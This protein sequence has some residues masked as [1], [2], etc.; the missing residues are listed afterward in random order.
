MENHMQI[1]NFKKINNYSNYR[2]IALGTWK[3][4]Y[5]PSTYSWIDLEIDTARKFLSEFNKTSA[6]EIK[7]VNLV[8]QAISLTM[9]AHQD[10]NV[11]LRG[12]KIYQRENVD[13]FHHVALTKRT[14]GKLSDPD[15]AGCVVRKTEA[16]SLVEQVKAYKKL[17]NDTR[18]G[19]TEAVKSQQNLISKIPNSLMFY[20]LKISSFL[21]YNLNLK[22]PILGITEDPF[23]SVIF[24]DNSS[25]GAPSAL[26]PLVA[27]ARPSLCISM[28]KP[29]KKPIV[30]NDQ[31]VIG[32]VL[33]L[34]IT[35]DHRLAEGFQLAAML[36]TVT[37]IFAD[38][39]KYLVDPP[40]QVAA[41]YF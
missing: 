31:I 19:L 9:Y 40:M 18:N 4:P 24:A 11:I 30:K 39:Q 14:N 21:I 33:P 13:L 8:A 23:A 36:R 6:I 10:L 7:I 37:K 20:F 28:G 35:F 16:L 17:I 1:N 38:P 12:S 22:M 27:Y 41:K 32:E 3:T 29:V 5:D 26:M 2:K 25:I 34:A 15:L